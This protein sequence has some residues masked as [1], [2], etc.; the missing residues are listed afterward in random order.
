MVKMLTVVLWV[1]MPKMEAVCSSKTLVT[2]YKT[3][4]DPEDHNQK[5]QL[6][7]RLQIMKIAK[8]PIKSH[9]EK[10]VLVSAYL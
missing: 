4:E 5:V 7:L 9:A 10:C 6:R 8:W 1:V 3:T 2:I